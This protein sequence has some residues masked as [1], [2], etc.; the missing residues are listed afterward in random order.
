[1]PEQK[2][3]DLPKLGIEHVARRV[4]IQKYSATAAIA[5]SAE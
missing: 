3:D 1:L 4:V 2:L 5:R